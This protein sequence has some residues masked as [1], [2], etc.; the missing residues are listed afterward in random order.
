M[1]AGKSNASLGLWKNAQPYSARDAN[2]HPTKTVFEGASAFIE[3]MGIN[4]AATRR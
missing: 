3:E 2:Q 1:P 4:A